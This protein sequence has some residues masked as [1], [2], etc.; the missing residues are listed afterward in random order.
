MRR[1]QFIAFA[2]VLFFF[3]PFI[4]RAATIN[5][6]IGDHGVEVPTHYVP[7][8]GGRPG[9]SFV[10]GQPGNARFIHATSEGRVE[11]EG[12]LDPD[13]SEAFAIA[14]TDFGAPSVF[15][16]TFI[17]PLAPVFPNPSTVFD[18]LS[19][20]VTNGSAAGGVTV[21]AMAPPAAIPTDGDGI[22]ELQVYTLSDDG[23]ATYKNVGLDAG[24]TTVVP[25]GAFASGM[26]GVFNQGPIPTI[27]GGPWT[28]MRADVNFGLS[29]GGDAFTFNG[30]KVLIPEPAAL[31]MGLS[32]AALCWLFRP[33]SASSR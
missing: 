7:H 14:V 30:A 25:L 17:L 11:L 21:T 1:L 6:T 12:E 28:H 4:V 22:V 5:V 23:G 2:S 18:S 29:G 16:F 15:G 19:G 3:A 32:A 27:A 13:P 24:P 26:Y 33:R 10:I 9:G 8:G 20:S 31:L